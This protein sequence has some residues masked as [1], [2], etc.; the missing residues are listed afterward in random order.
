MCPTGCE[1]RALPAP[2]LTARW[3]WRVPPPTHLPPLSTT[4]GPARSRPVS[5]TAEMDAVITRYGPLGFLFWAPV[6][7]AYAAL[8]TGEE[9]SLCCTLTWNAL[10]SGWAALARW[11]SRAGPEQV[12]LDLVLLVGS[13]QADWDVSEQPCWEALGGTLAFKAF[14][15]AVDILGLS[16]VLRK[17][18][19]AAIASFCK[20]S[21]QSPLM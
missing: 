5:L 4:I 15:Q 11:W 21:T 12:L 17:D 6:A 18:V 3:C 7:S 20:G 19:A 14:A 1:A 9:K 16:Y 10:P 13:W 8:L 2:L